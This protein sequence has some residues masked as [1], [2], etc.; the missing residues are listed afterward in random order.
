[1]VEMT[2]RRI[3]VL[4]VDDDEHFAESLAATLEGDERVEVIAPAHDGADAVTRCVDDP[5]DVVAMDIHMPRMD[6]LE[7]TRRIR[8][9]RCSAAVILIS[10]SMFSDAREL[11]AEAGAVGYLTKAECARR[12]L[13]AILA[14]AAGGEMERDAAQPDLGFG[15]PRSEP[16]RD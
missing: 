5:P 16:R 11:A 7:A 1:V 4:L 12:L 14:A 15:L 9:A 2:M 6:G 10:G 3:R 13:P 8:E